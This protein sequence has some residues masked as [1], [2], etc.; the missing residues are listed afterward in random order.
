M[1]F[2]FLFFKG[3]QIQMTTLQIIGH[4]FC[5]ILIKLADQELKTAEIINPIEDLFLNNE[6]TFDKICLS[7]LHISSFSILVQQMVVANDDEVLH[8]FRHH[9]HL[10][11]V[12]YHRLMAAVAF[13]K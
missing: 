11:V 2:F 1:P 8:R 3:L 13:V 5:Q 9:H 6:K 10:A 4:D 12:H 7:F